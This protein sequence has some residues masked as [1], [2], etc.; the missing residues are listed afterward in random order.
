M[1]TTRWLTCPALLALTLVI[2]PL[3]WPAPK[4]KVMHSFTGGN[5]G[6]ILYG[7]LLLDSQGNAYGTTYGGARNGGT[8]FELTQDKHGR[9]SETTLYAF[10]SQ[11]DC[12]DGALSTAGLIF[13]TSGNLYGT[14]KLGGTYA[15][16]TAFELI[17]RGGGAW[18][19]TVIYSFDQGPIEPNAGVIMDPSGNLYGTAGDA[20]ELSPGA[21]GWTLTDLDKTAG[22]AGL[23]RDE[24][25][26][27][28]GTTEYG[29]GSKECGDG[30]GTVLRLHPK[31]DGGWQETILHSFSGAWWDGAYP[32]PGALA[33][34]SKGNLYGTTSI[35]VFELTPLTRWR[36][37]FTLLYSISGEPFAGVVR[38]EAG[39]LYGTTGDGG[40]EGCGTI[41]KLSPTKGGGQWKYKLLHTFQGY[42]GC[43]P[44]ANLILDSKGNLYG[45]TELGGALGVGVAF[46]L[47]P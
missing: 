32:G 6:E 7:S 14:T 39:N 31:P 8:V 43:Y 47:T 12:I 13:D 5:D 4:Y 46:E 17:P 42:D 1:P 36:W 2:A 11:Q 34:D 33:R 26:N 10:C 44:A 22:P 41:F 25:G 37:R 18:S 38:D 28:Y 20:F 19:E 40:S 15:R 27:L 45:T 24:E 30:C 9:W 23:I 21:G 29:G 35:T 3:A 16:G